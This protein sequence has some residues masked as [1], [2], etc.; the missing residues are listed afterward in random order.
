MTILRPES[1]VDWWDKKSSTKS[2]TKIKLIEL[3]EEEILNA[4]EEVYEAVNH[5]IALSDEEYLMVMGK[6]VQQLL[7]AKNGL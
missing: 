6:V 2:F 3:T 5:P 4:A 1:K 7:K